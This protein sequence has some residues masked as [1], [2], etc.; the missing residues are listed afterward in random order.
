MYDFTKFEDVISFWS[1]R[2]TCIRIEIDKDPNKRFE[3]AVKIEESDSGSLTKIISYGHGMNFWG[4]DKVLHEVTQETLHRELEKNGF[5]EIPVEML[6]W[7]GSIPKLNGSIPKILHIYIKPDSIKKI[8]PYNEVA[9]N[10]YKLEVLYIIDENDQTILVVSRKAYLKIKKYLEL[11]N[12]FDI[13]LKLSDL[14]N[15]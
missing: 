5:F 10:G 8:K 4:T 3:K 11:M 2:C 15:L 14:E 13:L 1:S 9:I 7:N 6:K 12:R